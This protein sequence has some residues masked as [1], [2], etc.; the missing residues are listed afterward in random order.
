MRTPGKFS[1]A[2]FVDNPNNPTTTD[3]RWAVWTSPRGDTDT[4]QR[5]VE[6][7]ATARELA[8]RADVL[9]AAL[10]RRVGLELV[11]ATFAQVYAAVMDGGRAL[12]TT[13]WPSTWN[14]DRGRGLRHA[15]LDAWVGGNWPP[16]ELFPLLDDDRELA[17]RVLKRAFKH[18]PATRHLAE[19]LVAAA[20]GSE[21]EAIARSVR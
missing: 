12:T 20:P 21:L 11:R 9:L 13:S 4:L 7:P 19:R 3:S 2:Q 14:W 18:T 1:T 10:T 5:L 6:H 8:W 15:L 17:R 16:E